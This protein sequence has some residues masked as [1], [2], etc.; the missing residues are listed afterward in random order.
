VSGT[1]KDMSLQW[2][3]S[4][5]RY[6]RR[7]GRSRSYGIPTSSRSYGGT[8]IL[9]ETKTTPKGPVWERVAVAVKCAKKEESNLYMDAIR[10]SHDPVQNLK[11]IEDELKGTIGKALGRQGH[12]IRHALQSMERELQWR[13]YRN[14]KILPKR[15]I[16]QIFF[17]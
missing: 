13:N 12:K 9:H 14:G 5:M 2:F 4:G 1:L 16:H 8:L 17:L 11:T 6:H 3:K 15:C 10:S 7:F